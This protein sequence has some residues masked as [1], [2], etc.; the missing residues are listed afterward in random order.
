MTTRQLYQ[1]CITSISDYGSEIWWNDQKHFLQKFQKLQNLKLWKI[2]EAFKTLPTNAMK[3][4]VNIQPSDIRLNQKNQKLVLRIIKMD[5]RHLTRSRISY[6]YSSENLMSVYTW[7]RPSN[8]PSGPNCTI[9][10]SPLL[11]R[12]S[13]QHLID[14]HLI[15]SSDRRKFPNCLIISQLWARR[16]FLRLSIRKILSLFFFFLGIYQL[17]QN[18]PGY[19][20][21]ESEIFLGIHQW[22][23]FT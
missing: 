8:R 9:E 17:N 23:I 4:E 20:S 13:I 16:I 5:Q 2:L 6:S 22:K 3:I 14:H 21:V 7:H 18:F 11:D 12:S 15:A 19:S 10:I 1:T